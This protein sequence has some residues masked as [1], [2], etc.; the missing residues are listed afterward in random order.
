MEKLKRFFISII[1]QLL[2]N[3]YLGYL[4]ISLILSPVYYILTDKYY[5][6]FSK[7]LNSDIEW[8]YTA[9]TLFVLGLFIIS[10][11]IG[12]KVEDAVEFSKTK[13]ISVYAMFAGIIIAWMW[14]GPYS[15]VLIVEFV[16][17]CSIALEILF[18]LLKKIKEY[19]NELESIEKITLLVPVI[20]ILL[21][22]IL[23]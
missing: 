20:T 15:F 9:I 1:T 18:S 16:L 5:P 19:Y 10:M 11:F 23:N 22:S 13:I 17:M 12:T 2:F 8:K 3:N 6:T 21:N 4:G 7:W 14:T